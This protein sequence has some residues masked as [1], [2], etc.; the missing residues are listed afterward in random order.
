M[1]CGRRSFDIY[2]FNLHYSKI[3]QFYAFLGKKLITI[4]IFL[5]GITQIIYF[6][7]LIKKNMA[8]KI[9][10]DDTEILLTEIITSMQDKKAKDIVSINLSKIEN[11]ITKYFVICNGNST[12]Q[13]DS[14]FNNVMEKVNENIN[15]KPFHKEGY[16]N[17]EWILIDYF[18]IVVHIF[19]KDV[20]N[21]YKLEEL[22]A[23]GVFK[24]YE[25]ID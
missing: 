21:F 17:S 15:M 6:C 13:V 18:D 2:D 12:T 5:K 23:D 3:K 4:C 14:I 20:R 9:V 8:K 16:E 24:K 10:K 1:I 11:S 25:N 19:I 22:W 7:M